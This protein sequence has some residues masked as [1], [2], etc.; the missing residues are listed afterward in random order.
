M[1]REFLGLADRADEILV[2]CS[3]GVRKARTIRRKPE[4]QRWDKDQILAVAITPLRPNPENDDQRIRTTMAPGVA[5]D[6]VQGEPVTREEVNRELN[7]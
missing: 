7:A 6:V 4:D 5:N 1:D 3:E 2:W